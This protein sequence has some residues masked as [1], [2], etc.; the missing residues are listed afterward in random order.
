VAIVTGDYDDCNLVL[1]DMGFAN[2][3]LIDGLDE[4]AIADFLDDPDTLVRYDILC[5]SG[6]FGEDGVLYDLEGGPGPP[7]DRLVRWPRFARSSPSP[8]S[9]SQPPV[10]LPP[11]RRR[12]SQSPWS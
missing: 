10:W 11:Q 4:A 6:G 9:W 8:S 7:G 2:C 3:V 1:N 12:S 5:F